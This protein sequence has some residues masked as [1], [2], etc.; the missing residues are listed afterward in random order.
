MIISSNHDAC[1]RYPLRNQSMDDGADYDIDLMDY[2]KDE[3][4][5]R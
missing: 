2:L 5:I 3:S 4:V 1:T